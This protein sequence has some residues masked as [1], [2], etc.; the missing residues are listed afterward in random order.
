MGIEFYNNESNYSYSSKLN[1]LS[2]VASRIDNL[3]IKGGMRKIVRTPTRTFILNKNIQQSFDTTADTTGISY[4]KDKRALHE[5]LVDS[6]NRLFYR[7]VYWGTSDYDL[8]FHLNRDYHLGMWLTIVLYPSYSA[9]IEGNHEGYPWG[10]YDDE[11][12]AGRD[13][14]ELKFL[15]PKN[16]SYEDIYYFSVPSSS[17]K[18]VGVYPNVRQQIILPMEICYGPKYDNPNEGWTR[19]HAMI[20]S[21]HY[22]EGGADTL[23]S[24]AGFICTH[25]GTLSGVAGDDNNNAKWSALFGDHC[26]YEV[27]SNSH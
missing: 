23:S 13:S 22:R 1:K 6:T 15:L 16:P 3:E 25:S 5:N 8:M 4:P 17:Y 9:Y 18:S 2:S 27:G 14:G 24:Y 10:F 7:R 19:E 20:N 11:K 12:N 21:S 26:K